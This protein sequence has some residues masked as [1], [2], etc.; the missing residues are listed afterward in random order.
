MFYCNAAKKYGLTLSYFLLQ[1]FISKNQFWTNVF[2]FFI[3]CSLHSR[4]H[5]EYVNLDRNAI[6]HVIWNSSRIVGAFTLWGFTRFLLA[7]SML[8]ISSRSP[9][10]TRLPDSATILLLHPTSSVFSNK[11]YDL[12]PKRVYNWTLPKYI[13]NT[14]MCSTTLPTDIV[15]QIAYTFQP[16]GGWKCL[17]P[18]FK[19]VIFEKQLEEERCAEARERAMREGGSCLSSFGLQGNSPTSAVLAWNWMCAVQLLECLIW[20]QQWATWGISIIFGAG[21]LKQA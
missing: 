21:L 11:S 6:D 13:N 16:I 18:N 2:L 15:R 9:L 5:Q 10:A 12:L 14:S 19:E 17:K 8:N 7:G 1:Y 4:I 20:R 3:F